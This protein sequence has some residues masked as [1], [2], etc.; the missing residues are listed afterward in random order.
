MR[1]SSVV[2]RRSTSGTGELEGE[3]KVELNTRGLP[4][5]GIKHINHFHVGGRAAP[6]TIPL[7][8][9]VA[10]GDGTGSA[11][12]T[13]ED[14]TLNQLFDPKKKRFVP[15]AKKDKARPQSSLALM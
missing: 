3:V 8:T 5:A 1:A 10:K 11:I 7:E 14:V 15:R 2:K 13:L 6:A 9:I 12:T 4:Q